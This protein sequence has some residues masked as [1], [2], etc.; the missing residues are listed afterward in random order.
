MKY[1][2][3]IT[4]IILVTAFFAC[5]NNESVI[6][7]SSSKVELKDPIFIDLGN[8]MRTIKVKGSVNELSK[9][10]P[11]LK[12]VKN[13]NVALLM[14]EYITAG[15]GKE[16]GNT[17]YFKNVGNKQVEGDFVPG[18]DLDGIT[19]IS[20]YVDDNRP[21]ADVDVSASNNAIDSAMATWNG[22][23]CSDLGIYEI[24][25]DGRGTGFISALLELGGSY[26]YV[27]DVVHCGWDV[28]LFDAVFGPDSNV[29]GV[30]FTIVFT[31]EEG[32]L[33]DLDNNGKYDVAWREIYFNDAYNWNNGSTY[34]IETVSLHEAGHGLSQAHFGTAFRSGNGKLHFSP[35]AV[36]NAA[37]SGVQTSITETDNAG[38]CSNWSQ[39]PKI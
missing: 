37:Y 38:H 16:I 20:Y 7:D 31:D 4:I 24:P 19:N 9:S 18:L 32:N 1:L 2:K 8:T 26:D 13:Y 29:L 10:S 28:A 35:R 23:A 27:A 30:T 15:D 25:Y 21:T 39:W 34:D 12:A 14:A 22:I 36:M 33:I 6:N 17:V 5:E 3:T 11:S